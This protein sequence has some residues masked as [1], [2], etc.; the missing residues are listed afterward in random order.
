MAKTLATWIG[1]SAIALL[2]LISA[3]QPASAGHV[4]VDRT[5]WSVYR[6]TSSPLLWR[7][8][9][10]LASSSLSSRRLGLR[11]ASAVSPL[12]LA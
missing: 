2:G 6:T 7:R 11:Q 10:V 3:P 12:G 1:A 8:R 4:G 5:W 9:L